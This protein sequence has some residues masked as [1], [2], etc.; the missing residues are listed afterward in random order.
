MSTQR[1]HDDDVTP[2]AHDNEH[3]IYDAGDALAPI[4]QETVS[5]ADDTIAMMSFHQPN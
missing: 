2:T 4:E 3:A 5:D 1:S